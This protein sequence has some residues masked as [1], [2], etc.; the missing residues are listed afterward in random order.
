MPIIT[1]AVILLVVV[2]IVVLFVF[3]LLHH[4]A[5]GGDLG[6][7]HQNTQKDSGAD[8]YVDEAHNFTD[9]DVSTQPKG[10]V[11]EP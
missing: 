3:P 7:Q 6:Q 9:V 8:V 5:L 11:Y 2:V 4:R 10:R 1:I